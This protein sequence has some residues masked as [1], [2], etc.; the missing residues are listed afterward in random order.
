MSLWEMGIGRLDIRAYTSMTHKYD[1]RNIRLFG[2]E[3]QVYIYQTVV[4]FTLS[5][6]K[7]LGE[8]NNFHFHVFYV[9]F[10]FIIRF[11]Y[12]K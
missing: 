8:W 10:L 4:L 5:F 12:L 9:T 1:K 2:S 7:L 3:D 11:E 6:P